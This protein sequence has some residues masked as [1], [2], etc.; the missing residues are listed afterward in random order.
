MSVLLK[1]LVLDA[2]RLPGNWPDLTAGIA[3]EKL[4]IPEYAVSGTEILSASVDSRRGTPKILLTLKVDAAG[5]PDTPVEEFAAFIPAEPDIP[6]SVRLRNPVVVGTGPAG[7]Y[8]ALVLAMAGCE[9]VIIDSGAPADERCRDY[10]NFLADR[11]LNEN[12][13]LLI[14]EGGAGTFSDG[15]LY[16]GTRDRKAGWVKRIMVEC[17]VPEEIIWKSRAH[18]GSDFLQSSAEKLRHKIENLGGRFIFHTRVRDIIVKNGQCRGVVTASGEKIFAPAVLIAPGLGGRE[19]VRNLALHAEWELKPFQ[20]GCRIEHP[21]K[22]IDR[23][24]YRMPRPAALGA[25]EYH[26]VARRHERHV[27][28]FCMC[29]GG[30]VV[31]ATAWENHSISNGMSLF[32]RAGEF[33][34]SCLISTFAP[35]ELGSVADIYQLINS[36]EKRCFTM[37]G[38]DYT[39]PAQDVYAFL[40]KEPGLRNSRS[41][42]AVG[43][44]SGRIDQLVPEKLYAALASALKE[45]DS[46]M[47]GFIRQGKFIG[48]ESCV[49]APLRFW[50]NREN[51]QSSIRELYL[52]GEVCGAAGGIISAACDGIRCAEAMLR[53]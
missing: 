53:L 16:T 26:I 6:G 27:A 15:K 51:G 17:G 44:V 52:A 22:F 33:A 45:F 48:I 3:A 9:P 5:I 40:R 36:L 29:P 49:S 1:N 34:N 23:S 38:G 30:E 24:M 8:G 14:G 41:D 12:S 19:L 11:K 32:A 18:A 47:T 31:N 39:L 13:N 50:R 42:T 25:A 35:G 20:I 10:R 2:A 46:R 43:V 7:I 4:G 21:Q 37:G 28:S